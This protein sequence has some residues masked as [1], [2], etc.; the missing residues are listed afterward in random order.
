M[1]NGLLGSGI[2]LGSIQFVDREVA[3]TIK[4][5]GQQKLAVHEQIGGNRVIDAMGPSPEP[6]T[7]SGLFLGSSASKRARQ[8]DALRQSGTQVSL[9]WGTFRYLVVVADFKAVY[10][11]EW[12]VRYSIRCQVVSN[13]NQAQ[14]VSLTS[15]FVN[16]F[17]NALSIINGF[18]SGSATPSSAALAN[19]NGAIAIIS[20][21]M[22][23]TP[24][25]S[26]GIVGPVNN[27]LASISAILAANATL[28]QSNLISI[29]GSIENISGAIVGNP[30]ISTSMQT[31][32][33]DALD[34]IATAISTNTSIPVEV[35]NAVNDTKE[36]F[37]DAAETAGGTILNV[38]LAQLQPTIDAANDAVEKLD[39]AIGLPSDGIDLRNPKTEASVLDGINDFAAEVTS[40]SDESDRR[41]LH[42]YLGRINSNLNM[43]GG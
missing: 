40:R 23:S 4:F 5:G 43:L 22:A 12:E 31:E 13:L 15:I 24:T 21:A 3:D 14:P 19:I 36:L 27:E 6:I 7:W 20:G 28:S 39:N 32:I 34:T 8:V 9:S 29:N 30:A 38:S 17:A 37:D 33:G 41:T 42:A 10:K 16:D 18:G 1:A 26:A 25:I 35:V 11:H 2:L